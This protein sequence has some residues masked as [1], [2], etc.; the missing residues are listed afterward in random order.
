[1]SN[2]R[3]ALL[4]TAAIVAAVAVTPASAGEVE[5]SMSAS[6]HIN[7]VVVVSDN[8]E[9]TTIGQ[10]DSGVSES[11]FR[12]NGAAKSESMTIKTSMELGVTANH[13]VATDNAT[14]A[15]RIRIRHS[16]VSVGSDMG[17]LSVGH[18]WTA[19]FLSTS[20]SL[21]GTGNSGF[22]DGHTIG[23][24]ALRVSNDTGTAASGVSVGGILG[25]YASYRTNTVKYAT[26]NM[27]G[28]SAQVGYANQNRVS[29]SLRYSGDFDGTKVIGGNGPFQV[30]VVIEAAFDGGA[31]D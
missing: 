22:Y 16:Y 4:S 25:N 20:N 31:I 21:S 9:N 26:P 13:N 8:G 19:D 10:Q 17:T 23:N 1:M 24:E 30:D 14:D 28:F 6:G 2:F 7:R 15:T 29:A 5:K 12:I 3:T 27:G 11:R 18:T